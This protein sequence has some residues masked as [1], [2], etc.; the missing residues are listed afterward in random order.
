VDRERLTSLLRRRLSDRACVLVV[1]DDADAR[2]LIARGV[3]ELGHDVVAVESA[4]AA[5]LEL[6]RRKPELVVVDLLMPGMDGFAL[7]DWMRA[8]PEL[9]DVPVVVVTAK[10]LTPRDRAHLAGSV[11]SV[12]QKAATSQR[13]LVSVLER[14]LPPPAEASP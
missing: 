9:H 4:T 8:S 1:D 10:E 2:T 11:T 7:I 5:Q 3:T 6:A 13:D 12:L 14:L